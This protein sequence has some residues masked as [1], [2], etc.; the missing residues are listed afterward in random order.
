MNARVIIFLATAVSV[1]ISILAVLLLRKHGHRAAAVCAA[2]AMLFTVFSGWYSIKTV[3]SLQEE[4]KWSL[5]WKLS[6]IY[7][8]SQ[9]CINAMDEYS[10]APGDASAMYI[11]EAAGQ[12]ENEW[13]ELGRTV[14]A[15]YEMP[16]YS[17]K[18]AEEISGK[19]RLLK[20]YAGAAITNGPDEKLKLA[21]YIA[22]V[23]PQTTEIF[24]IMRPYVSESIIGT[25]DVDEI[26]LTQILDRIRLSD[27]LLG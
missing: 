7:N 14:T 27:V 11:Y 25:L 15:W 16:A 2:I 1:V 12:L 4:E 9:T 3:R 22:S 23:L 5:N 17:S 8:Y 26:A 13:L 6:A 24:E 18:T 19:Y 21:E 20:S 10:E